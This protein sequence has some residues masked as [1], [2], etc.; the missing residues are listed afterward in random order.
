MF[1]DEKMKRDDE[2]RNGE[3]EWESDYENNAEPLSNADKSWLKFFKIILFAATLSG[4]AK[5][6]GYY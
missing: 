5:I 2:I 6:F 4:L 3:Y 1:I